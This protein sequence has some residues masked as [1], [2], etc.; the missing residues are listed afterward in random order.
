MDRDP[1]VPY[2][3]KAAVADTSQQVA[4]ALRQSVASVATHASSAG[5]RCVDHRYRDEKLPAHDKQDGVA[6]PRAGHF[7]QC[8]LKP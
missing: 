6:Y 3:Y 1:K 8:S 5:F 2:C 4:G 7:E